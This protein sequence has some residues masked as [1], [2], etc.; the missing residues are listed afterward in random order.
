[1]IVSM[2][3]KKNALFCFILGLF[4]FLIWD[5]TAKV[6]RKW[7][8]RDGIYMGSGNNTVHTWTCVPMGA[9]WPIDVMSMCV[10]AATA[11]TWVRS[12][13]RTLGK[14]YT[15]CYKKK[16]KKNRL[17]FIVRVR[18]SAEEV[19]DSWRVWSWLQVYGSS[20]ARVH[21]GLQVK[22]YMSKLCI[23]D[24]SW[25]IDSRLLK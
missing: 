3:V 2:L 15:A 18:E 17:S 6:N 4:C 16:K 21:F 9:H 14:I 24:G 13:D 25:Q 1:M 22:T 10:T 20:N 12:P 11:L 8:R 5:R 19:T 7:T 23:K